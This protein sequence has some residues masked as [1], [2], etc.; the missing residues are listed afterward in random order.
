MELAL[1]VIVPALLP[2]IFNGQWRSALVTAVGNLVLLG[3]IYAVVGLGLA[4]ILRWTLGRLAGQLRAS[5]ELFAR[6][7]PLLMIFSVVL[8]LTDEMW[9]VF[10]TVEP[11]VVRRSCGPVRP[12]RNELPRRAPAARGPGDRARGGCGG[13]A[14]STAASASTSAW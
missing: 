2:L 7:I 10:T 4:S 13:A 11:A 6:A 3:L 5:L 9:Q 8:F 14:R 12:P 1:F